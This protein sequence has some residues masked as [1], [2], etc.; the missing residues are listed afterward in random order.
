MAVP[1]ANYKL[2]PYSTEELE[3]RIAD[4]SLDLN[5]VGASLAEL[6]VTVTAIA[7]WIN[8]QAQLAAE[9]VAEPESAASATSAAAA[10]KRKG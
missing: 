1:D 10:G 3:T 6:Q 2:P 7:N 5:R 4:G 8:R 9:P